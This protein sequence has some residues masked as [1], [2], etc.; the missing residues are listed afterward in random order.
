MGPVPGT[1]QIGYYWVDKKVMINF[2]KI[3]CNVTAI[4]LDFDFIYAIGTY[5]V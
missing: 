5:K 4:V 3:F 2:S 1:A